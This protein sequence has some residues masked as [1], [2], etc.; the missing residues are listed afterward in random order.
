LQKNL[1]TDPK[2]KDSLN[3]KTLAKIKPNL[4]LKLKS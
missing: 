3:S 2:T 4:N 1:K